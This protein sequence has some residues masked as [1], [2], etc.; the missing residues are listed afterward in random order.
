MPSP[1]CE[2]ARHYPHRVFLSTRITDSTRPYAFRLFVSIYAHAMNE[3]TVLDGVT[4]HSFVPQGTTASRSSDSKYDMSFL[5]PIA[6]PRRIF[7]R[8]SSLLFVTK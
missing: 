8:Y 5:F 1:S 4:S 6:L 3:I 2:C 7:S